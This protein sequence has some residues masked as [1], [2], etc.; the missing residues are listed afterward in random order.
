MENINLE[1][2]REKVL[3]MSSLIRG[4]SKS[5]NIII[6]IDKFIIEDMQILK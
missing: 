5:L 4:K 1:F 3:S 2:F 6:Y